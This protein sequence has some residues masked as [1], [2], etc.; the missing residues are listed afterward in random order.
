MVFRGQEEQG[1]HE[2]VFLAIR[3]VGLWHLGEYQ[4][5]KELL[6]QLSFI[7]SQLIDEE[8]ACLALILFGKK[9]LDHRN[10]INDRLFDVWKE[11]ETLLISIFKTEAPDVPNVL[12]RGR[13]KMGMSKNEIA[14]II[15]VS[16]RAYSNYE[17]G[18][19]SI[20]AYSFALLM[21]LFFGCAFT[22]FGNTS[23][24]KGAS[25]CVERT[26]YML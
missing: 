14:A 17:N 6:T 26:N 2:D 11:L 21:T 7:K 22:F 20:D 4:E 13:L 24:N 18:R 15:G 9:K 3:R 16:P 25:R 1:F 12:K 5:R 19:R 8:V 10:P 23:F